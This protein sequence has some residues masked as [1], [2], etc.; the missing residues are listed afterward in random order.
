MTFRIVRELWWTNREFGPVDIVILPGRWTIGPNGGRSSERWFSLFD[1]INKQAVI[2]WTWC[3]FVAGS[4]GDLSSERITAAVGVVVERLVQRLVCGAATLDPRFS[5]KFLTTLDGIRDRCQVR[6]THRHAGTVRVVADRGSWNTIC[7]WKKF[8][9]Y[10]SCS[11]IELRAY[12][13]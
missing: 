6:N 7:S 11:R 13:P 2:S 12:F 5:S 9:G 1:M 10:K 4:G 8:T 3:R